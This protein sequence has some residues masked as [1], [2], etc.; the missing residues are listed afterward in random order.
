MIKLLRNKCNGRASSSPQKLKFSGAP[1][2]IDI[3]DTKQSPCEGGCFAE[4]Y[5]EGG[6]Y[7]TLRVYKNATE[8]ENETS[9]GENRCGYKL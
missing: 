7:L 1:V 3:I 6:V 4:G 9:D 2:S 5:E 8:E